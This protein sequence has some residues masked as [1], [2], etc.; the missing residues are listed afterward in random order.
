MKNKLYVSLVLLFLF[1]GCVEYT[2]R[3]ECKRLEYV[4]FEEFRERGIEV[5]EPREIMK[6]KK[7]YSYQ[8]LLFIAE[9]N[10]GIH[11]IDNSDKKAPLS[12]AFLKISGNVDMAVKNSYLYVDSYMDLLVLDISN[13]EKIKLVTRQND[14]F[15]YEESSG[16]YGND[17]G[18]DLSKGV[19]LGESDEQ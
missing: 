7:I 17:C 11:V 2:E 14:T 18:Y 16:F 19:L 13:I 5:L 9:E 15:S 8:N 4:T 10:K 6:A 12:K 3:E 1:Q